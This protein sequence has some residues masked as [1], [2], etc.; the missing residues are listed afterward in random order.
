[1][2]SPEP[3]NPAWGSSQLH[4]SGSHK[5]LS[6][7]PT[8][9]L[10]CSSH[11]ELQPCGFCPEAA[12][13]GS[14]SRGWRQPRPAGHHRAQLSHAH[15]LACPASLAHPAHPPGNSV[16]P[17]MCFCLSKVKCIRDTLNPGLSPISHDILVPT[18]PVKTLRLCREIL[19][20]GNKV[21]RSFVAHEL[22]C[23]WTGNSNFYFQ[24]YLFLLHLE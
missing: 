14:S 10:C 24:D 15:S 21:R 19:W 17:E 9:H 5:L 2:L 8:Q 3:A 12:K 1:M 6:S 11:H 7:G 4:F 22:C 23:L 13:W 16:C 18:W 20:I